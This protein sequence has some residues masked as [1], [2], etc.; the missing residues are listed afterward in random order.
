MHGFFP[1]DRKVGVRHIK[2]YVKIMNG[3]KISRAALA[4]QK[5]LQFPQ[6]KQKLQLIMIGCRIC[7]IIPLMKITNFS[8]A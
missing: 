4:A 5:K 8:V 1:N 3:K 6:N 7:T 2:K